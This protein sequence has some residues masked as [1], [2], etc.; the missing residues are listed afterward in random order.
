MQTETISILYCRNYN[1]FSGDISASL[2]SI[3][4]KTSK[5]GKKSWYAVQNDGGKNSNFKKHVLVSSFLEQ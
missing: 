2:V 1:C 4:V 5:H 3:L